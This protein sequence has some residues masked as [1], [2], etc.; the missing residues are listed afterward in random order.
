L[1]LTVRPAA[2]SPTVNSLEQPGQPKVIG[3]W[4]RSCLDL[5]QSKVDRAGY[6]KMYALLDIEPHFQREGTNRR[7]TVTRKNPAGIALS[8]VENESN[9]T[10]DEHSVSS[11]RT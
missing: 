8:A 7:A 4:T 2:S 3:V 9:S 1:H 5:S 11:A 10:P 6:T